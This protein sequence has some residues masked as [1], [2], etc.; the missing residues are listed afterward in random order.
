MIPED[1]TDALG[2]YLKSARLRRENMAPS[3]TACI[4]EVDGKV[5]VSYAAAFLDL[6]MAYWDALTKTKW[7]N[8][9]LAKGDTSHWGQPSVS[10]IDPCGI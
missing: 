1:T 5:A 4:N 10:S 6:A 8:V 2:N 3:L 7:T 9:I